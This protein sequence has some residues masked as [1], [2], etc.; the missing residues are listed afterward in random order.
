MVRGRFFDARTAAAHEA[1]LSSAADGQWLL[2]LGD[3][4]LLVNPEDADVSQ[5][6]GNIPRRVRWSDGAEFETRDNDGMDVL[7]GQRGSGRLVDRLERRWGMAVASLLA[8]ALVSF[9]TIRYGLPAA[10]GWAAARVPASFDAR[11]GA[12][13]L[14]LLDRIVLS[15]TRLPPQRQAWLANLFARVTAGL[16]DGHHYQLELRAGGKVGP[17]AFALPSGIIVMTDELVQLAASDEELM[18]VMAHEAGHVRGRHA[19]RH[20]IQS[21]GVSTLALVVL[22]DVSS[23]SALATAAPVL[24]Q[25]RHSRDLER[26]AD[27]FARQWLAANHI[28]D[29]AF[30]AILCRMAGHQDSQGEAPSFLSTHP[31]VHERARCG[32]APDPVAGA[33]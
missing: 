22:G 3:R 26:E 5:R 20:I 31:A 6:I 11:I 17:N 28:A 24:L 2:Q 25:A 9:V 33:R 10:A 19:L 18:A 13:S 1:A 29:S 12:Q 4:Q 14:Q 7:L 15:P 30:D 27:G 21:A 16:D 23:I 8:V 32:S